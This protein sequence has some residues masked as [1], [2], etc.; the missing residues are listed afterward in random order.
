MQSPELSLGEL[1]VFGIR[2]EDEL[3]HPYDPNEESWNESWFWDFFSSRLMQY[4]AT[5]LPGPLTP[6]CR[7]QKY[8]PEGS[9]LSA[10]LGSSPSP[11]RR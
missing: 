8:S 7:R 5:S 6:N 9:C 2:P 4:P 10:S 3:P 1:T 11:S